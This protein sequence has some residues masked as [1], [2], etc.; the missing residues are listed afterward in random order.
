VATPTHPY[1]WRDFDAE[2]VE[3][4]AENDSRFISRRAGGWIACPLNGHYDTKLPWREDN[5]RK[6]SVPAGDPPASFRASPT[7]VLQ[8]P[9]DNVIAGRDL[10]AEAVSGGWGR[11]EAAR[12]GNET[13]EAALAWNVLR[14]LQELGELDRAAR[15]LAEVEPR[16]EPELLFWERRIEQGATAPW[17]AI[18]ALREEL[19]PGATRASGPDAGLHIPGW[20]WILID[21]KF[22]GGSDLLDD[23]AGVEAWLARFAIPCPGLFDVEAIR[24]ARPRDFPHELLATIALAHRLRAEEEQAV[25]VALARESELVGVEKWVGRCLAESADVAFRRVTW[26]SLYRALDPTDPKLEP[27]RAYLENKS[28][29]LRPAF[30][31]QEEEPD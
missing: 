25:V 8:D 22:G 7:Y 14:S 15:V 31:L 6:G 16:A 11:T 23:P 5:H 3:G 19:D 10:I 13:S 30:A 4:L 18:A 1:G 17:A 29:G 12:L 24:N 28:Y 26:E 27:L 20:G 9:L 2:I 21:V